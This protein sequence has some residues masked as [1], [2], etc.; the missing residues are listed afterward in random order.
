[1][2]LWLKHCADILRHIKLPLWNNS[3]VKTSPGACVGL[4]ESPKIVVCDAGPLIHLDE[5]NSLDLLTDFPYLLIPEAVWQETLRHR[6]AILLPITLSYQLTRFTGNFSE[7]LTA[8][9]RLFTL[10]RGE[11]E[12]LQL[13]L[14]ANH[15]LLLTDD[16]A[17]RLAANQLGFPVHG[18]IGILLRSIRHSQRS[19]EQI[20]T[21][22]S[23]LPTHST[24]YLKRDLLEEIIREVA[25]T[26][27]DWIP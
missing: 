10:H 17:A 1:M 12:A 4:T 15:A 7:Q 16:T 11:L 5:I 18:T 23:L 19:K 13:C 22:L 21:L 3:S 8:L 24:L 25:T 27:L 14:I 6:P 9:S 20:L 2:N 26:C